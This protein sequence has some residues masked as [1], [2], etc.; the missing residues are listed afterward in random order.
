MCHGCLPPSPF[1]LLSYPSSSVS[2]SFS[3]FLFDTL[4]AL[5][6]DS[7]SLS[8]HYDLLFL[9]I[10]FLSFFFLFHLAFGFLLDSC[11]QMF[12]DEHHLEGA[13]CG[14]AGSTCLFRR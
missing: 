13:R 8:L 7:V 1:S 11:F 5:L 12:E 6:M 2:L 9:A 10:L 4:S 14:S 3:S